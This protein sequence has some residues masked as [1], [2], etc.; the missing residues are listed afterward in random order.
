MLVMNFITNIVIE[1]QDKEVLKVT[2]H[3]NPYRLSRQLLQKTTTDPLATNYV[4]Q[5]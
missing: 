1:L 5:P 3:I 4:H 2:L